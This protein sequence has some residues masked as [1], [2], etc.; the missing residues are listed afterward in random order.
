MPDDIPVGYDS[1]VLKPNT[2]TQAYTHDT[3]IH[4]L[5]D[6]VMP[7]ALPP[8]VVYA[9]SQEV[10]RA[11]SMSDVGKHGVPNVPPTPVMHAAP[12]VQP[13]RDPFVQPAWEA[14]PRPPFQP[15][16]PEPEP[17][18]EQPYLVHMLNPDN[19]SMSVMFDTAGAAEDLDSVLLGLRSSRFSAPWP[20][21]RPAVGSKLRIS[22]P[23]LGI[24]RRLYG[25]IAGPVNCGGYEFWTLVGLASG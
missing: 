20:V 7:A 24:D 11:S 5:D 4:G 22:V 1:G 18:G 13:A 12:V 25:V 19:S 9:D 17:T 6:V 8:M 10:G 14:K 15:L 3:P 23:G 2:G 16:A 21:Y